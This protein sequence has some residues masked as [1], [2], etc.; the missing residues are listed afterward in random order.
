M[1]AFLVFVALALGLSVLSDVIHEVNPVKIPDA[2]RHT[3]TVVI[4]IGVC[5]A[6]D[7]SVFREFGQGLRTSWMNPVATGVVLVGAGEFMRALASGLGLNISIGNRGR[8][9]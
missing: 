9:A 2:L 1:Y 3:V 5:W 6:I 7:Y 8:T 4:A